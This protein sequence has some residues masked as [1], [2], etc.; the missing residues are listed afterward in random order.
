MGRIAKGGFARRVGL[1]FEGY[2]NR[3]G[4][5]GRQASL[6]P[7]R[8]TNVAGT[9]G[10]AEASLSPTTA[11]PIH[12][13]IF[14]SLIEKMGLYE[15]RYSVWERENK[16]RYLIFLILQFSTLSFNC[17]QLPQLL[18]CMCMC[19]QYFKL[20]SE[21]FQLI[22]NMLKSFSHSLSLPPPLTIRQQVGPLD[23]TL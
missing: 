3:L 13:F 2:F 23:P 15:V 9:K 1:G 6:R 11:A 5:R 4:W 12:V 21:C 18:N 14:G 19:E 20:S 22:I 10:S 16:A 7:G 8:T 17:W